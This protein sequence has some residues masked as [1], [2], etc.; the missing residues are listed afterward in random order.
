MLDPIKSCHAYTVPNGMAWPLTTHGLLYDREFF[1]IS[2]T[3]GRALSQK[4]YPRMA[5]IQPTLN[6]ETRTMSVS[7]PA[8]PSRLEIPLDMNFVSALNQGTIVIRE[9]ARL[10]ADT[11]RSL[12]CV[13]PQIRDFFSAI[14]GVECTLA[15][16]Y[17]ETDVSMRYFKPHLPGI[18]SSTA[19]ITNSC[20]AKREIWLSNESP[21]LLISQSSVDALSAT[22]KRKISPAVFRPNF[23]L[24]GNYAYEED[25]FRRIRIGDVGFDVLGQCRRCHMV[26]V[27]PER[28]VKG[29]GGDVY[30]GLGKTRRKDNGGVVFGIH[31]G[32]EVGAEGLVRV[33]D[34]VTVEE[35]C[36]DE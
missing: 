3:A 35:W 31:M 1:L 7:S 17:P 2:T 13:S 6:L 8:S 10:C 11:I 33:A 19:T 16:Y 27:D 29:K 4:Q 15:M 5:L 26:C 28:G 14:V 32:L 36:K 9:N 21:F 24:A 12:V 23:V 25:S 30:L 22:T 18:K 34:S 20:A